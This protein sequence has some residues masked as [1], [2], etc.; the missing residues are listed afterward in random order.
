MKTSLL[1]ILLSIS[2]IA[3]AT[4]Y[5]VSSS[6]GNDGWDGKS[7]STAWKTIAKVNGA[8]FLPGDEIHFMKGDIWRESLTIPS[9]GISSNYITFSSYG[10]GQNPKILGS[11]KAITWTE[12]SPNIWKSATSIT[13]NP[14][15]SNSCEIFFENVDGTKSWGTYKSGTASL[16]AEYN[17][18]WVSSNIY[19]YS[20][21]DP[22]TKYTSVEIPQRESGVNMNKKNY[23]HFDGIDM[24]YSYHSGYGYNCKARNNVLYLIA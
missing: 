8:A 22:A 12:S 2:S 3:S 6:T 24:F 20:T 19:V 5:Y 17:W 4:N 10:T 23:I 16:T 9:S 21:T 18:T 11:T 14:Y 13:S 7:E 15:T 1:V